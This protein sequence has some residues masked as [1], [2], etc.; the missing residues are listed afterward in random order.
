MNKI[1]VL[2]MV[3]DEADVIESFV[4]HHAAVADAICIIDH[5]SIDGTS[6]IL[7]A[8]VDEGLPLTVLRY[9]GVAQVQSE[10]LTELMA[11]VFDEGADLV[12]PL[13]ADEFLW[14]EEGRTLSDVR[15]DLQ[16]LAVDKVYAWPW[17]RCCFIHPAEERDRLLPARPALRAIAPDVLQKIVIGRTA[18]ETTHCRIAQGNHHALIETKQGISRLVP[19][20]LGGAFLAH[21]PWRSAEQAAAKAATGW[22]ANV[23][24]YSRQTTKA[25]HWRDGFFRVLAG[26]PETDPM[27]G[28]ATTE[29]P[30]AANPHRP[31]EI[32]QRYHA[33]AHRSLLRSV[34]IAAENLAEAYRES[35]V[36]RLGRAVS[37]VL[38]YLGNAAAFQ[39]SL[40]SV[41]TEGYPH[42]ELLVLPLV[43]DAFAADLPTF[44]AAQE[45][46][47]TLIVLEG[48][49]QA[50]RFADLAASAH[51][52][53][54]Q[55]VLPGDELLS[56]DLVKLVCALEGDPAL[57][58]A[59]RQAKAS[60]GSGAI[61]LPMTEPFQNADGNDI[62]AAL[63]A[64]KKPL[65]GGLAT[66]LFR[67]ETM[68]QAGWLAACFAGGAFD[69]ARAWQMLLPDAVL[70][71]MRAR[72]QTVYE[73]SP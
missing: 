6:E 65:A 51:G 24:K 34:L 54:V 9:D 53:Y 68:E 48:A 12:L 63:R 32:H 42:A 39:T 27:Q 8:L 7:A 26:E 18:F 20:K 4:R 59:M 36:L 22:L 3:R 19:Q 16:R 52:D 44:L 11:T 17:V 72:I 43:D 29:L 69:E 13:D 30:A 60:A 57:T 38:P 55:W 70:G 62:A 15:A 5:A 49:T 46:D 50:E 2:S 45:T 71:V 56:G 10:L 21:F 31:D 40:A 14:P 67:R 33:L 58:L 23:A 47:M 41:F 73:V 64:A 28:A 35:E 66:A 37:I 25:F 61:E 1:A